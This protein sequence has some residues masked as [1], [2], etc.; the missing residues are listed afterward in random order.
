MLFR[1]APDSLLSQQV[2]QLNLTMSYEWSARA[3]DV[4]IVPNIILIMSI[5]EH[6]I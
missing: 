5:N 3:V 1:G 2:V 6:I 4:I